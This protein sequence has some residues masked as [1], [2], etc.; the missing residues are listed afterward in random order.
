MLTNDDL[1]LLKKKSIPQE[2]IE[3]QLEQFQSGFAYASLQ[4][5]ATLGDGIIASTPNDE[6]SFINKYKDALKNGLETIKF[7]P[8]SGAATRMF[9]A[10]FEFI[11]SD[12][13]QQ[14]LLQIQEPYSTF[15]AR[16]KD[17]AFINEL[18][19]QLGQEINPDTIT[20]EEAD[21]IIKK[22]LLPDGLNYGKL[23]KG[24][25]RFHKQNESVSTPVE[26]HLKEAAQYANNG[27]QA[28]VHFTVSPEHHE[29]FKA[30]LNTGKKPIEQ[31]YNIKFDVDFSFQ[32]QST[33]TIAV[34]PDNTPF[35]Q[36]DDSLLFR[37]A[38]HGALIENLNELKAELI[39]VKNIDNV[40]PE[41]QLPETVKYKQLLAGI[42]LDK[43]EKV[44]K[45]LEGL[46]N[47]NSNNFANTINKGIEFLCVELQ[48]NRVKL[49]ALSNDEKV[50]AIKEK[51]NRPIRIC[52]MVKNEGEPGGGPFWVKQKDGS[53]SLQIVEGA[54]IDPT[55]T[56]QQAILKASTHFNPVDLV[57][58]TKDYKG[59]KFDLK[60]FVDPDTG[61]ISEKTQNGKALK[62]LELP[63]LWNG[64]MAHW[65]TFFVEVPVSTFNP[66]KTVMDLLRPQH[67]PE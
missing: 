17:F 46:D 50:A 39:F 67:Q 43:K 32:K 61:F 24:L 31:Q 38:G 37:P 34:N 9:K 30:Q 11:Q 25:L 59:E 54:Q 56:E 23:P 21:R 18:E 35:R 2:L 60:Q 58:Y 47:A 12:K 5:A 66:V 53:I 13:N 15:F 16:I 27:Q 20:T 26:E 62:A 1:L 65:L 33:D 52:G 51:L 3:K 7:V 49:E 57:C 55:D 41:Y 10:L 8:A 48:M 6:I 40:V 19:N 64:A 45:I 14:A 63:G 42:L 28:K 29:L 36:E 22:I 4:K 44:F